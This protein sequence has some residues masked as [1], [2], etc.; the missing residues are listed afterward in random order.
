M[1]V[2]LFLDIQKYTYMYFY[3]F[4]NNKTMY[5][6]VLLL[7]IKQLKKQVLFKQRQKS[8]DKTVLTNV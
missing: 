6:I 7:K 8:I 3:K 2:H 1:N 5:L 4:F